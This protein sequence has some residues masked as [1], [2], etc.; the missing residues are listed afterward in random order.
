MFEMLKV[1]E[2]LLKLYK[3]INYGE[4]NRYRALADPIR[5]EKHGDVYFS[6]HENSNT[7]KIMCAGDLMCEPVMSKAVCFNDKFLFEQCFTRVRNVFSRSDFAIA[8][9]ETMVDS[10][11]PYAVDKHKI[12]GRYHCNAPVEYLEALRYAGFDELAMANNHNADT[13]ADGLAETI[14]Q[15]DNHGFMHTGA[16]RNGN[17]KRY[18]LANI[19]GI[20]VAVFS[21]TEH[22]NRNLDKT[23]FKSYDRD[24]MINKYSLAKLKKDVADAGKDG[25]EF[26]ICY[27]H[28]LCKEYSHELTE[29]QQATAREIAEAGIDCIMGSHAHAIQRYDII[30]T[31]SGKKVPVVYGLGNFITS[32]NT[33]MITHKS[34]IYCLELS[35][36]EIGRVIIKKEGCVPC[37]TVEGTQRSSFIVFPT[38]ADWRDGKDIVFFDNVEKEIIAEVGDGLAVLNAKWEIKVENAL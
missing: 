1:K 2:A 34:I 16:F 4:Y 11:A 28:F 33:G 6:T 13:G 31:S 25:A 30:Q 26:S 8:N 27:I 22:I 9:L 36:N 14:R 37:R 24:V 21:Y 38:P 3:G 29:H 18:I 19:N 5:Y 15:V 17:E 7:V 23:Y 10:K 35:R 32:D 12:D 20:K